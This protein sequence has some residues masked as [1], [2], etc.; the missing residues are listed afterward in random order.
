MFTKVDLTATNAKLKMLLNYPPDPEAQAAVME[1]LV[2]MVPHKAALSWLV[3]TLID[4]IGRWPGP[5]EVRGLL[6]WKFT[7]ADG[8]EGQCTL[9]GF[10]L[11]DGERISLEQHEAA[12]Q[13]AAGAD[14]GALGAF[15]DSTRFLMPPGTVASVE[16][17]VN[18]EPQK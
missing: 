8:V 10:S 14:S 17:T 16:V 11:E 1:L 4:H 5:A 3:N 15:V 18:Q 13:M 2:R 12:R 9:P 7:P 6:C